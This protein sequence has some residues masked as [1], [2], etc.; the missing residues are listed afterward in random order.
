MVPVV[1]SGTVRCARG[2]ACRFAE[3]VDGRLVGGFIEAG[4]DWDLGHPD[5][6]SVG[7]PEHAVCN[8]GHLGLAQSGDA[9]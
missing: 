7:G 5:G 3:F 9:A 4:S 6:V 1:A 8:R 2:A